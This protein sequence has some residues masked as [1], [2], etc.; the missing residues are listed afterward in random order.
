M[1]P[2]LILV[3]LLVALVGCAAEEPTEL[4]RLRVGTEAAYPPFE[5]IDDDGELVGLDVDLARLLAGSLG[6][7]AE[8]QDQAFDALIP[9][10]QAGRLD[11]VCSAMSRTP[12]RD[13]VIDFTLPY[14]QVPMGVLVST[15]R[16]PA[17]GTAERLDAAEVVVA[18]QRGTSGALKA[19]ETFPSATLRQYDREVDAAAEV[20]AGRADAFVYDMVSVVKLH[21]LHPDTTRILDATLGTELYA[22]GLPEGSPLKEPLDEFLRRERR[23]GGAVDELLERWLGDAARFRTDAE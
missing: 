8:F 20:A 14:A 11:V 12:E 10:L 23:P 9:N 5:T 15:T 21:G 3:L 7:E 22:V 1:R 2:T 18:V 19:A 13:A 4:V 16:V 17:D 6:R